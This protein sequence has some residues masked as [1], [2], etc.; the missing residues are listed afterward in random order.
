MPSKSVLIGEH[1]RLPLDHLK[2]QLAAYKRTGEKMYSAI[3]RGFQNLRAQN[4]NTITILVI[5]L[6]FHLM[7]AS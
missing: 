1:H 5:N 4:L 2:N 7:S 6:W 3:K